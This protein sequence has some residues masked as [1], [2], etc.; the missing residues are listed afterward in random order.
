ME[1]L[2]L[3]PRSTRSRRCIRCRPPE[4]R[5]TGRRFRPPTA[6]DGR[7]AAAT[8]PRTRVWLLALPARS[9]SVIRFRSVRCWRMPRDSPDRC[10]WWRSRRPLQDSSYAR[11]IWLAADAATPRPTT[12]RRWCPRHV[13]PIRSPW[14]H[15]RSQHACY[16]IIAESNRFPSCLLLLCRALMQEFLAVIHGIASR[17]ERDHP[18]QGASPRWVEHDQHA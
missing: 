9:A 15:L 11:R 3:L 10:W 1:V 7:G 2:V 6:C 13:F 16:A 17:D 18:Q 4:T 12:V 5:H 8:N 14:L